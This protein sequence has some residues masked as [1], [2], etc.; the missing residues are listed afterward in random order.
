MSDVYHP[1]LA[2]LPL[3]LWKTPPALELILGQEGIAYETIRDA[4]P[5]AFRR[6]RF[7]LY[8]SR[9]FSQNGLRE[10]LTREH[11]AIDIDALRQNEPIDPFQAIIDQQSARTIWRVNRWN[12]SERVSR[13]PKAW[14]RRRLVASIREQLATAGGVWM[15]LSPYPHP[16]R[17]VFSLRVD[18][19]EPVADDYH[20]FAMT[21]NLFCDCCTHFVST[22]A[23]EDNSEVFA[24]L[25]RHDTQS[26]GHF[27]YI[28][29]DPEA[30]YRNLDR[31]DRILRE[32]GFEPTGFAAP[33][34]RWNSG[35]DDALES[36][37]YQ[38]S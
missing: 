31:A 4:H 29:R 22:H 36:L 2:P 7:V 32:L 20:R 17:S 21:R 18:L 6:G 9:R 38:Y 27:H 25:R 8:D 5:F 12:L 13:Y 3:L 11:V 1:V 15:S 23:Y 28:Y 19:D 14:I 16:F 30:N 24:D 10:L 34:G 33:H 37:G 35:L 26:H